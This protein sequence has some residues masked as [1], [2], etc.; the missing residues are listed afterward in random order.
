MAFINGKTYDWSKVSIVLLGNA[1]ELGIK[2]IE[3]S[4]SQEK[5]NNYGIGFSAVGR[6]RGAKEATAKIDIYVESIMAIK[7]AMPEGNRSLLDI[8]PFDIIVS[9][10]NATDPIV[11]DRLVGCEFKNDSRAMS[12]GQTDNAQSFE[13][14]VGEI[15]WNI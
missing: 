4:E 6:T 2:G 3:Y 13:L 7:T 11:S 1:N 5:T 8:A 15:Q 9:Y 14:V 10:Q 12:T